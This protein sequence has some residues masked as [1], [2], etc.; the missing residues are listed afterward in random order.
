MVW[1]IST[2]FADMRAAQIKFS[3]SQKPLWFGKVIK[4]AIRKN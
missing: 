3:E 4:M 1:E 2:L